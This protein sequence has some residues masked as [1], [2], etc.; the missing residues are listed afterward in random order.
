MAGT[1]FRKKVFVKDI[2]DSDSVNDVFI[3]KFRRSPERYKNGFMFDLRLEDSSDGITLRYFGGPD[4]KEANS[5]FESIPK[6]SVVLIKATARVFNNMLS[7]N[8][9]SSDF[10]KVLSVGEFEPSDFVRV[11]KRSIPEMQGELRSWIQ[12]VSDG[13]IKVV[14][15][16]LF[17][18]DAD[19]FKEFSYSAAAIHK[20]HA[21]VGGLLEHSLNLVRLVLVVREIYPQLDR[22]YL[23]AGAL[24]QD[25]GKVREMKTGALVEVTVEGNLLGH[26]ALGFH[27]LSRVMGEIGTPKE[28]TVKLAHLVLS[29]HVDKEYGSPKSPAF[30]EA[31]VVALVD[32]LDAK[33]QEIIEARETARTD[34]DYVYTKDFG[35]VYLK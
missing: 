7:L 30:P 12:S 10:F 35:N 32:N 28:K 19:F 27:H 14:L 17:L 5:L 26:I 1:I 9:N 11:S 3:V 20:H 34:D 31:L 15:D 16:R 24:L 18:R 2:K 8:A 25:I 29:H 21:W 13:D 4:E 22:D 33:A 23:I 6:G